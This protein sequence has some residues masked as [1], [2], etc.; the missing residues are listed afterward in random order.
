MHRPAMSTDYTLVLRACPES[1]RESAASLVSKLFS[2]KEHTAQ[3]I[4]AS[5]PIVLLGGLG[6]EEAAA[7]LLLCRG[8]SALG[9]RVEVSPQPHPELP[10]IDWPRRP[11]VFK[12]E[13]SEWVNDLQWAL[14]LPGAGQA[15]LIDVLVAAMEGRSL[16]RPAFTGT[17][18]P[19]VTPFGV[20]T[21]APATVPMH[22]APPP[23]GGSATSRIV[24]TTPPP[25]LPAAPVAPPAPV[26]GGNTGRFARS[27]DDP[28]ARLNELFPDDGGQLP[29]QGD[30]SA[31]LNRILPEEGAGPVSP[32][33]RQQAVNG[34]SLFI[35][36]VIDEERRQKAA[37]LIAELAKIPLPE[38]DALTRKMIIQVLRNVTKEE[39]EAAK[40][41]FAKIGILAR[42][43]GPE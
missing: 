13:L 14:P 41:Q 42:I 31:I 39:A 5:C 21:L 4:V 43:K 24:R 16:E 32:S 38:A 15:R 11:Q 40:A 18:L 33:G 27:P 7:M 3:Q 6:R 9:A 28:L 37:A 10:K 17:A 19:E 35:A 12:R 8:L 26:A 36:K 1:H 29:G 23:P 20:A 22:P 34:Y 30:I 25:P 2:L